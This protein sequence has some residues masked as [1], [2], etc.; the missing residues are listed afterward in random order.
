MNFKDADLIAQTTLFQRDSDQ[1]KEDSLTKLWFD[2]EK[3]GPVWGRGVHPSSLKFRGQ[4]PLIPKITRAVIPKPLIFWNWQLVEILKCKATR[5]FTDNLIPHNYT[6]TIQFFYGVNLKYFPLCN[7]LLAY[8][9]VL[10]ESQTILVDTYKSLGSAGL[11]LC[12]TFNSQNTEFTYPFSLL[13]ESNSICKL[14]S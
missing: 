3:R 6:K 13:L 8:L 2:Y 10:A 9:R 14:L 5:F 7:W 12:S 11:L 4:L 1:F